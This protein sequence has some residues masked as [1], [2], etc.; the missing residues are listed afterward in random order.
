MTARKARARSEAKANSTANASANTVDLRCARGDL[1]AALFY[2]DLLQG[3]AATGD[4]TLQGF[5][6]SQLL[7]EFEVS[8]NPTFPEGT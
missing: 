8:Q 6:A 2:R 3:Y 5:P 1:L 7:A 4:Q